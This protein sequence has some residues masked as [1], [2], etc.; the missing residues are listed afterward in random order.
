[1]FLELLYTVEFLCALVTKWKQILHSIVTLG[2]V[3]KLL[4]V[5]VDNH[6]TMIEDKIDHFFL[7]L[8]AVSKLLPMQR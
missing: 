7:L 5:I 2:F 3:L 8:F 6:L 4:V 1:M